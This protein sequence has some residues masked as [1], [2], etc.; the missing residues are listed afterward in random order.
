MATAEIRVTIWVF[1]HNNPA[2]KPEKHTIVLQRPIQ[3]G[4]APFFD[5]KV[6]AKGVKYEVS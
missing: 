6:I 3:K 5:I 2:G 1:D 4:T